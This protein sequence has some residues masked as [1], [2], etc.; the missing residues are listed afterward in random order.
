MTQPME[1][2]GSRLKMARVKQGLTQK[3]L[4]DAVG[5]SYQG[6]WNYER[7]GDEPSA[8]ILFAL[9]DALGV[10]ARWLFSG[11]VRDD[12]KDTIFTPDVVRIAKAI[13]SQNQQRK[14]AI[15]ILLGVDISPQVNDI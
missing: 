5:I 15:A 4:G 6:V 9:S 1:S 8:T 14:Q 3:Q 10:D 11:Q 2:F 12:C 7:R 13:S